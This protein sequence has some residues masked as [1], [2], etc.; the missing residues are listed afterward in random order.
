MTGRTHDNYELY[1]QHGSTGRDWMLN[2]ACRINGT[3]EEIR[4][5]ADK[6]FPYPKDRAGR[7]EAQSICHSCPVKPECDTHARQLDVD[8]GVWAGRH[9]DARVLPGRRT[10]NCGTERAY[11]RHLDFGEPV[12]PAC[13]AAAQHA[14]QRRQQNHAKTKGQK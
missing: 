1:T 9:I 14:W 4:E 3:H 5:F 13:L 8:Y 7:R 11:Y 12:D 10:L 2:A 6:F